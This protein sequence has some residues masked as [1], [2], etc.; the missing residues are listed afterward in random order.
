MIIFKTVSLLWLLGLDEDGS[1]CL[2]R[3]ELASI[4]ADPH[5]LSLLLPEGLRSEKALRLRVKVTM[6]VRDRVSHRESSS[7]NG[8]MVMY[9]SPMSV[10]CQSNQHGSPIYS[11]MK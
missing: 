2:T 9:V 5:K 7:S 4:V 8:Q 10:Q 3:C 6:R 1:G 11:M